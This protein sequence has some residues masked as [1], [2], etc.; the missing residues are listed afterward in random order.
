MPRHVKLG[1]L[2]PSSNTA[3]EPLT[4]AIIASID[5]PELRITVHFSR[6]RVTT[7]DISAQAN[8]QFEL[9]P[10]IEAARLLADAEV[11][12]IGWS[13]TSAGWLGFSK[14]EKLCSEIQATTGVLAT[15]STLALN[16]LLSSAKTKDLGLVTPYKEALNDAIRKNYAALGFDITKERERHLGLTHNAKFAEVEDS[17]LND[18][19]DDVVKQGAKAVTTF[20]T[21]LRAAHRAPQWE[22]Q[23]GIVVF[24]T[25]STVLWDMLRMVGVQPSVVQGWGSMFDIE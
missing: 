22:K 23:H 9:Q 1:V 5:A 8:A 14:D 15:S 2:V 7:I 19:V 20:C 21:N 13:G 3:L 18:M 10:I 12:I 24:D 16:K 25:V 6:F 17:E 4:Q 11:D